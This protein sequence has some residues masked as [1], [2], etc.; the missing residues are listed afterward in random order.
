MRLSTFSAL[1]RDREHWC[2]GLKIGKEG[3]KGGIGQ[4]SSIYESAVHIYIIAHVC[5]HVMNIVFRL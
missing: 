2:K 4:K 1:R 3:S 5:S